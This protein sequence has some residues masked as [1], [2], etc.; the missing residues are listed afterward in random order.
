MHMQNAIANL[1]V[2][3][4]LDS[5]HTGNR[6]MRKV[7]VIAHPRL[8][9]PIDWLGQFFG[10]RCQA[11]WSPQGKTQPR[12][13]FQC[14]RRQRPGLGFEGTELPPDQVQTFE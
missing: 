4:N 14:D 10:E 2:G 1:P 11:A 12:L 6:K 13:E 3:A 8:E 7:E 5:R 9:R